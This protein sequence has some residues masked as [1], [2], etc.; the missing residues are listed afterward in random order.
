MLIPSMCYTRKLKD[1]SGKQLSGTISFYIDP[2]QT[3]LID[4]TILNLKH[5]CNWGECL[6]KIKQH[7]KD[8]IQNYNFLILLVNTPTIKQNQLQFRYKQTNHNNPQE[9]SEEQKSAM[10]HFHIS[11]QHGFR[12]IICSATNVKNQNMMNLTKGAL[13]QKELPAYPQ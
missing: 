10:I 4:R 9:L 6:L 1:N 3:F 8:R 2:T 7:F 13:F 12:G 5:K 11:I